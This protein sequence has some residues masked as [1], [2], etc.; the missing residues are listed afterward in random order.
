MRVDV[1]VVHIPLAVA[2]MFRLRLMIHAT[3]KGSGFDCQAHFGTLPE[4]DFYDVVLRAAKS[5]TALTC[6]RSKPSNH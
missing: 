1:C 2:M 3:I 5:M 4:R 6:S